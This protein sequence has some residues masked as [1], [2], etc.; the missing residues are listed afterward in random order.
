MFAVIQNESFLGQFAYE[1]AA[2]L[3]QRMTLEHHHVEWFRMK[4]FGT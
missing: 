1:N 2:F 3:C 4:M